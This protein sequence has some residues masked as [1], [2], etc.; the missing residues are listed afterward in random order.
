MAAR[1]LFALL[2]L[3]HPL[4]EVVPEDTDAYRTLARAIAAGDWGHTAFHYLSP[5]YA[6]VLAPFVGLSP[7]GE[8]AAVVALQIALEGAAVALLYWVGSRL[9]G[10]GAGLA[11]GAF[12]SVYGIAIYYSAIA[13]PVT[14]MVLLTL[15]VIA[16]AL[17]VKTRPPAFWMLP[18]AAL[19]LLALTRPNA[20]LMLPALVLWTWATARPRARWRLLSLLAGLA[21]VLSPFVWRSLATG[22][23]GSPFPV[24]GGINFYMGNHEEAN[25]MYVSVERVSDL[26]LEQVTTS[27]AEASRRA[28]HPLDAR[29]ASRYWFGAGLRFLRRAPAAAARLT[30]KKAA[31]FVRAEE[32]P[33][34]T[35]YTFARARLPLLGATLGFGVLLPLAVAG[36]V[37]ALG[38]ERRRD[39]DLWLV[40]LCGG[41]YAASVIA[42]FVSDRYRLPVVPL[43][44]LLAGH[45]LVT[46]AT[47]RGQWRVAAG[48]AVVA[49]LLA[50]Y[51]LDSFRYPEYA[52][53]YFQLGNVH[54]E[55]GEMEAAVALHR[56]GAALSPGEAQ[57]L[58]ELGHTYY[59]AGKPLEAE[60]ALRAAL[61]LEPGLM[62]ARRNLALLYRDQG[63]F[64][65]A[66]AVA[67]DEAQRAALARAEMERREH[68]P[69]AGAFARAQHEL[70]M[71]HYGERRLAEARYAFKRALAANPHADTTHFA[72]A[73]VSKDLRLRDDACAAI[74]RAA[75]LK[76]KD[77]EYARERAVLCP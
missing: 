8:R 44:C 57:P 72:L 43:F 64:E 34:N 16:A 25:G 28:G 22:G 9:A 46:L 31:M 2:F 10:A 17:F 63:L 18:G 55:R 35:N 60:M 59:K 1:V 52:K 71:Q 74:R 37:S 65:E 73:L 13:L 4:S 23:G 27:I 6:F 39:P 33:L 69:D 48:A 68:T 15:L 42:F 53:D 62:T 29:A 41:L 7:G 49:A 12:Y 75:D 67:G 32:I 19:G 50:N 54:R 77:E 21:L 70:G 45:G 5:L 47:R 66:I 3:R 14:V 56:Q 20:V 40:I 76:P 58:V 24:N 36:I 26:P 61:V 38:G 51:P 30:L 11:A